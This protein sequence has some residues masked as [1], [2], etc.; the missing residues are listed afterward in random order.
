M[1]NEK[2][3]CRP[4]IY[5]HVHEVIGS[6]KISGGCCC[7]EIH[8]HRFATISE[9]AIPKENSHVHE[10]NFTTDTFDDH[11]H[12]FC[13]LTSKAIPVGDG[14]HVHFIK[15][16]TEVED[17]HRHGFRVATLID[18]PIECK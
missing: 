17:E 10:V 14:R 6:T 8:N 7:E 2:E 16:N 13:G 9:N 5:P 11:E 15:D 18:N 4:D 12:Q 3:E 1:S